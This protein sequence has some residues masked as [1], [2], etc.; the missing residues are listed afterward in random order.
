MGLSELSHRLFLTGVLLFLF[1]CSFSQPQLL[2]FI[3]YT[4]NNGLL[5][6]H[7]K[8][9]LEDPKGFI[10]V[11]SEAG[12]SR[13]DGVN[14]KNFR[15]DEADPSSLPNNTINDIAVNK[16]GTIWLALENG[17]CYYNPVEA[18]F[19]PIDIAGS[20][21]ISPAVLSLCIDDVHHLVWFMTDKG[22]F[23]LQLSDFTMHTTSCS[24]PTPTK[25]NAM[26]RSSDDK[27]WIACYRKGFIIYN[28]PENTFEVQLPETWVLNF[29][30]DGN[31][32]WIAN[33]HTYQLIA[34]NM[35]TCEH[36]SWRVKGTDGMEKNVI[37]TGLTKS[38][39]FSDSFILLSTLQMGIRIFDVRTRTFIGGYSKDIFSKY[40]LPTD[41]TN[42]IFSDSRGILWVCTWDG[43]CKVN[44]LE[45]Q[46]RSIEI[47]FLQTPMF[48][49]YNLIEGIVSAEEPGK[50]WLGVN[51][52]G[53]I[54]YDT[55]SKQ[56]NQELLAD[57]TTTNHFG[58]ESWTDFLLKTK[59][60]IIWSANSMGVTAIENN[61]L[62]MYNYPANV[63]RPGRKTVCI[64]PD[65][66]L[67]ITTVTHL[68]NF[69]TR[70]K[71]ISCYEIDTSQHG[72][73]PTRSVAESGF[74]DD[75]NLWTGTPKGLYQF[76]TQT[77][78]SRR[79][80]LKSDPEYSF[81]I[82]TINSLV[83][84][85][86]E[87]IYMGTP[88]GLGI[89]NIRTG[90]YQ[91]KGRVEEVYPILWKSLLRDDHGNIWIYTTH[92][93]F[94]YD[95]VKSA[96]SKFTTSDGIYSF[97][98]DP[99]HL[100]SFRNNFY[101]GYRGAYTE[102]DPLKVNVNAA[103]VKPLVTD[104]M[105]GTEEQK[106]DPEIYSSAILP[107][108]SRNN[109]I[110]FYFTGIDYTNSDRIT[111][112]YKLNYDKEWH[113]AG[114]NRSVTYNNLGPGHYVFQLRARNSSGLL[115]TDPAIFRF[116]VAPTLIQHLW[117]WPSIA[118]VCI[119]CVVFL[120]NRSVK[121]IR[122]EEK[123]KTETNQM[124]AQLE[125]RLLRSQMNPHFIF[126]SLNSIQKYIWENKEED[127]AEY[128]SRF[129][130][131]IRA[132]L[133]NSRKEFITLREEL[134]VLKLY[135]ELEHRRS[136]GKFDYRIHVAEDLPLDKL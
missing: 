86:H 5:H 31:T 49:F 41:F 85:H 113:E 105:I 108:T 134:D 32:M 131:L 71:N 18:C 59:D 114:T 20:F 132:I 75:G 39:I 55:S 94:K 80:P 24:N 15:H 10:W 97:S 22:L 90:L 83:T 70:S 35:Q 89:Y 40:S 79:I 4:T 107:L 101:I 104:V 65:Q 48:A 87:T 106:F 67:W 133:E 50:W 129:A 125:T 77:H 34:W 69:D 93:L 13:F 26:Y 2:K 121:K 63:F 11:V 54:E 118:L 42:Y 14:F 109:D 6:N 128:L 47:P 112:S 130:K 53:L 127:A 103:L 43:L 8:K 16:A 66:T 72:P 52:C 17:L 111:F 64:G 99:T 21:T 74:C 88:A 60:D 82:N 37:L 123:L 110:S 116:S 95:P 120:A 25:I 96:F 36:A 27:L 44:V 56:M 12:L 45:Q 62:T 76:N 119:C 135:I 68:V 78:L 51:G 117:F 30:E 61:L 124:M 100:F 136:N 9:C 122:K 115:N 73:I 91:L 3:T 57:L 1:T 28:I 92:S 58:P 126:N 29:Y 38:P 98:S 84:D 7:I 23:C 102:F 81:D 33:W 46:F 19:T